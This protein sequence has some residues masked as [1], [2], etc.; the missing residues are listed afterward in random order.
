VAHRGELPPRGFIGIFDRS[1]YEEV[2]VVRV[3][4]RVDE[5]VWSQRYDEINAWRTTWSNT[6]R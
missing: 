3:N 6:A 4:N 5:S 1:Q 2:L